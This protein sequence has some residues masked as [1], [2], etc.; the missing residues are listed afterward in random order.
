MAAESV[1]IVLE[2]VDKA[3]PAFVAVAGSMKR[4]ADTGQKLSGVFGKIFGSLGLDQ[5]Q[6]YTGQFA[7]LAGQLKELGDAGEK[8]GAGVMAA[9]AGIV[10][11]VAAGTYQVGNMIA[12]W[13]MQTEAWRERLKETFDEA[14][15]QADFLTKKRREQFDLAFETA[16]LGTPE[17]R[18]AEMTA[19]SQQVSKD[20]V[21]QASTLKKAV[22]DLEAVQ[23]SRTGTR[24]DDNSGYQE[25]LEAATKLVEIETKRLTALQEQQQQIKDFYSLPSEAEQELQ[26]R[27]DFLANEKEGNQQLKQL[28]MEIDRIRDPKKAER[29]QV[30]AKAANEWQRE[31]LTNML[32][33]RE[34]EEQKIKDQAAAYDELRQAMEDGREELEAKLELEGKIAET[35]KQLADEQKK[36]DDELA[37]KLGTPAP[38]LQA[39]QS[40]LLSRSGQSNTAERQAKANEK[41]AE[42]T[43]KIET[44]QREQQSLLEDIRNNTRNTIKVVT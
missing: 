25:E 35:Q 23:A 44:L 11:A 42:L 37:K 33:I 15:K 34:K 30:L 36:Q 4:T 13:I 6:G 21:S 18:Q 22:A 32:N 38:Q 43:E 40:R 20:T 16:K 1:Q 41:V 7:S 27:R 31:M 29:E 28:Q 10:A 8:G 19:L 2:G 39:M 26:K 9:K 14:S 5:L 17:Q 24:L 3:S 12:D